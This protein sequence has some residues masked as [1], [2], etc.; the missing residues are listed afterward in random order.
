MA[1]SAIRVSVAML[2]MSVAGINVGCVT[3][4]ATQSQRDVRRLR[5]L[6]RSFYAFT[7][8]RLQALDDIEGATS[9]LEQ[10]RLDYVDALADPSSAER[11][12]LLALLRLAEL[13]LDLSARIRRMP[14]PAGLDESQQRQLDVQLSALALPLEATGQGVLLQLIQ[15]AERAGVDGRFVKRAWLYLHLHAHVGDILLDEGDVSVLRAE[16]VATSF[17]APRTLLEAGRV[18]QRAARR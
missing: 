11:D 15:R 7:A 12:R 2:A 5:A 17:R 9:A 8:T 6:E 14:Y 10:L 16:L 13:H 3:P 18:G 1:F 4:A